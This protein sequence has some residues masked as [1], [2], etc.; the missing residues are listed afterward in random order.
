MRNPPAKKA[1]SMTDCTVPRNRYT[2]DDVALMKDMATNGS[3]LAEIGEEFGVS[4][5]AIA[6]VFYKRGERISDFRKIQNWWKRVQDMPP[7][8][9]V[10]YLKEMIDFMVPTLSH[11]PHR[12]D[13]LGIHL[14]IYDRRVLIA[15]V[16]AAP[17]VL[18]KDQIMD[19]IYADRS[20]DEVPGRK[21]IDMYIC[22]LRPK[23]PKSFGTIE[24]AWGVGYRFV[25]APEWDGK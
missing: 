20:A 11:M 21:I 25:P 14:Q 8:E 23:L 12:V 16:D 18:G 13:D 24:T 7:I 19:L 10:T 9:A 2:P 1:G 22:R 15:L 5:G 4:P 3:T 6:G 17:A